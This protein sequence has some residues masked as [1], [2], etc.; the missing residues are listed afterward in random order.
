MPD[1]PTLTKPE[2]SPARD[3]VGESHSPELATLLGE[4]GRQ[5]QPQKPAP[6]P[7]PEPRVRIYGLD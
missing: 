7:P 4:L 5:L 3:W 6:K 2:D 1:D